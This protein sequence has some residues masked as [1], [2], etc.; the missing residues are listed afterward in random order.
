M[1]QGPVVSRACPNCEGRLYV[2]E[3]GYARRCS[4][5]PGAPPP[6]AV[7]RRRRGGNAPRRKGIAGEYELAEW[8]RD[9]GI[10]ARRTAQRAGGPS[11]PDVAAE[12]PFHVE[13]KR[14]ER[15]SV[16]RA[17]EQARCDARGRPPVV[18]YRA[19]G[20]AWVAILPASTLLELLG[21][22]QAESAPAGEWERA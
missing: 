14:A 5:F 8:F 16:Y 15:I 3:D 18:F 9:R 6:A 4:C 19:S 20:R 22:A 17:I 11:S 7:R 1:S 10:R 21:L 13:A 2:V 12:L